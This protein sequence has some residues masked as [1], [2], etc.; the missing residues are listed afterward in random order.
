MLPERDTSVRGW[1]LIALGLA[2]LVFAIYLWRSRKGVS[3]RPRTDEE[4]Y[5]KDEE[6]QDD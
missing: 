5:V 4:M 1:L 6:V 3:L 2:Q